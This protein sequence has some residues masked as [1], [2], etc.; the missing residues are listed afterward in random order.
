MAKFCGKCGSPLDKNGLCPKCDVYNSNETKENKINKKEN[1]RQQNIPLNAGKAE[2]SVE[3]T[4][5]Q[6]KDEKKVEKKAS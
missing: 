5:E 1:S 6:N 3:T 2:E 4:Q